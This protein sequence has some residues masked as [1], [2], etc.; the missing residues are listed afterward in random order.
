LFLKIINV[1][2]TFIHLRAITQD[3]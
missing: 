1:N 2:L 3:I